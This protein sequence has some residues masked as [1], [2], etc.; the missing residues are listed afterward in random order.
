MHH[1]LHLSFVFSVVVCVTKV[2]DFD[3]GLIL[4]INHDILGSEVSVTDIL[5]MTIFYGFKNLFSYV[6]CLFLSKC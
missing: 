5:A 6:S 1:L 2:N 4:Y 3:G